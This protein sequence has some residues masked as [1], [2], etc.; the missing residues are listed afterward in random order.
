MSTPESPHRD[1]LP[2]R[3]RESKRARRV[4]LRVLAE[5]TLEVVVP[6]GF[7]CRR[8]PEI[9]SGHEGWIQR[10]LAKLERKRLSVREAGL[11]TEVNFPAT[12]ALVYVHVAPGLSPDMQLIRAAATEILIEGDPEDV[13]GC[14]ALLRHWLRGQA[15][16]I[17]IPWLSRTSLESGLH[18]RLAQIRSQRT[19]WASC[20]ARGTISLNE[21]L[22]FLTP[23]LVRYV[24]IHELC[25]T[26]HLSHSPAFWALVRQFEPNCSTLNAALRQANHLIP[27]WAS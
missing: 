20:S 25:H 14:R 6:P 3:I 2:Y 22:L 23:D 1:A 24:F 8:V 17:L 9:V 15:K 10:T 5:G 7:N 18:Y 4:L 11:P 12:G 27:A 16:R 13:E 26:V 19:R 21:K